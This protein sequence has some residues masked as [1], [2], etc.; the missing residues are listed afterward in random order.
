MVLAL[1]NSSHGP[2][3]LYQNSLNYLQYFL[4]Y[5]S[6]ESVTDGRTVGRTKWQLY[7]LPF[8]EHKND[9][10]KTELDFRKVSTTVV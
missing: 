6:D 3:T 1:G 7:A 9:T 5:A 2:L 4:R 8:G 10:C